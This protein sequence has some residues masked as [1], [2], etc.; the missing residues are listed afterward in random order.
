K[1]AAR[2]GDTLILDADRGLDDE[3]RAVADFE[4]GEG[5]GGEHD[6][7][8]GGQR[9]AP[10]SS[11]TSPWKG[12]VAS[13]RLAGG[14]ER[15]WQMHAKQIRFTP[16]RIAFAIRPSPCRGGWKEFSGE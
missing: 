12:E 5:G 9:G 15:R 6:E 11:F 3:A 13:R 14:G 8:K 7:S 2:R 16:R 4:I 1:P 10:Q